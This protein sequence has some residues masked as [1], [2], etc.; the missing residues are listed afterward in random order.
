MQAQNFKIYNTA[1]AKTIGHTPSSSYEKAFVITKAKNLSIP[2]RVKLAF[3]ITVVLILCLKNLPQKFRLSTMRFLPALRT[4]LAS[5]LSRFIFLSFIYKNCFDLGLQKVKKISMVENPVFL[6]VRFFHY[7]DVEVLCIPSKNISFFCLTKRR[8]KNSTDKNPAGFYN[9][10]D[11]LRAVPQINLAPTTNCHSRSFYARIKFNVCMFRRHL[12]S[13]EGIWR[14]IINSRSSK[15]L[16]D[17]K[18]FQPEI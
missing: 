4:R 11:Q 5:P 3:E 13:L 12:A 17:P 9:C 10:A 7:V 8:D 14:D 15:Q 1:Y 18:A 16:L 2:D 6:S